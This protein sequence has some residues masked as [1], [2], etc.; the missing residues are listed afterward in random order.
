MV[1]RGNRRFLTSRNSR[2]LCLVRSRVVLQWTRLA[3]RRLVW[4][5]LSIVSTTVP[6]DR[7][8]ILCSDAVSPCW[9]SS[10]SRCPPCRGREGAE[11]QLIKAMVLTHAGRARHTRCDLAIK[12]A[13]GSSSQRLAAGEG[14]PRQRWMSEGS[15]KNSMW[16]EMSEG[17]DIHQTVPARSIAANYFLIYWRSP[18]IAADAWSSTGSSSTSSSSEL[19]RH[20]AFVLRP[21]IGERLHTII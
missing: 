16:I 13:D 10:S 18:I 21:A 7:W 4:R 9:S 17:W 20:R 1:P 11:N 15:M 2:S 3:S 14:D 6:G 12:G 5:M 19:C 8:V